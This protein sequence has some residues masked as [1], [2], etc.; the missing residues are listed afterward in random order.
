[1][2]HEL[3]GDNEIVDGTNVTKMVRMKSQS[4]V[5][6]DLQNSELS[7]INAKLHIIPMEISQRIIVLSC[8]TLILTTIQ[9][10]L[11]LKML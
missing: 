8:T 6:A 10:L 5:Q 2:R 3:L 11:Q 9:Q 7:R 4:C 1:M